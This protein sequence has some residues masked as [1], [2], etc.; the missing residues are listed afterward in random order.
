MKKVEITCDNCGKNL[1]HTNCVKFGIG[2]SKKGLTKEEI[3][4]HYCD[5]NCLWWWLEKRRAKD[6]I[7]VPK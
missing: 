5:L 3:R 4:C 2:L 7:G 1:T 6:P